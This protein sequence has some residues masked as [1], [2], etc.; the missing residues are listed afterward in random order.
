MLLL[1]LKE[2]TQHQN[3]VIITT[4]GKM[5]SGRTTFSLYLGSIFEKWGYYTIYIDSDF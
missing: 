5:Q 2:L 3:V 4:I 1:K